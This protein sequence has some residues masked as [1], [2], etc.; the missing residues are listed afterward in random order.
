M[1]QIVVVVSLRDQSSFKALQ[2]LTEIVVVVSLRDQRIREAELVLFAEWFDH[3]FKIN[4]AF[5]RFC[6]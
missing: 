4:P 6:T 5:S 3:A 1:T 2:C